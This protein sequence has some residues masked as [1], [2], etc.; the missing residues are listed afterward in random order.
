MLKLMQLCATMGEGN[1]DALSYLPVNETTYQA[2]GTIMSPS[3]P[4][5]LLYEV[6]SV[7]RL[8]FPYKYRKILEMV[9]K[10]MN[11]CGGNGEQAL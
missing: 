11:L 1:V 7:I 5:I 2:L 9:V 4:H 3:N 6:V 10:L 8:V